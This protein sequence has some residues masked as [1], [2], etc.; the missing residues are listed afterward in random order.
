MS[1]CVCEQAHPVTATLPR[2]AE[3]WRE[4]DHRRRRRTL[5]LA[6]VRGP[7]LYSLL[8]K[9]FRSP[10]LPKALVLGVSR[11][12]RT[13]SVDGGGARKRRRSRCRPAAPSVRPPAPPR[14]VVPSDDFPLHNAQL[15]GREHGAV[16]GENA[17]KAV[18]HHPVRTCLVGALILLPLSRAAPVPATHRHPQRR[19]WSL[20]SSDAHGPRAVAR[21]AFAPLGQLAALDT[22]AA[23]TA[24]TRGGRLRSRYLGAAIA[25]SPAFLSLGGAVAEAAG[26]MAD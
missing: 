2:V 18:I 14:R 12:P 22:S 24:P 25:S 1:V 4:E 5:S 15:L 16:E 20:S 7:I 23:A 8:M 19:H 13:R 17:A 26:A 9:A 10:V 3:L 11:P 6:A 21:P